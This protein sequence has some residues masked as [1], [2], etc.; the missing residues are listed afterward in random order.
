[1]HGDWKKERI[2]LVVRSKSMAMR[3]GDTTPPL[4]VPGSE[5]Q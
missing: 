5:W 3:R 1:M 2:H 4:R